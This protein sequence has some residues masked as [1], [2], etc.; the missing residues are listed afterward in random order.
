MLGAQRKTGSR[1]AR[2]ALYV[3]SLQRTTGASIGGKSASQS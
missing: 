1:A 2:R 3:A